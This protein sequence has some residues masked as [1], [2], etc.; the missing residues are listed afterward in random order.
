[1]QLVK[2]LSCLL[3]LTLCIGAYVSVN[4]QGSGDQLVER[5]KGNTNMAFPVS[6]TKPRDARECGGGWKDRLLPDRILIF[7]TPNAGRGNPDEI[8]WWSNMPNVVVAM[9]GSLAASGLTTPTTRVC[10]GIKSHLS[11]K[12]YQY[13]YLWRKQSSGPRRP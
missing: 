9:G 6:I 3:A 2:K 11:G 4:A 12:D 13:L 7:N 10:I 8:R 5:E 1:M